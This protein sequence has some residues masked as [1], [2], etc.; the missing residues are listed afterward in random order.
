MFRCGFCGWA[1]PEG[2]KPHRII[3]ERR[4]KVYASGK[5][6]G[7]GWEIA[8]EVFACQKCGEKAQNA[9]DK[10]A[11]LDQKDAKINEAFSTA[12]TDMGGSS[13]YE[14][15]GTIHFGGTGLGSVS[16]RGD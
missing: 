14:R 12:V 15:G 3:T 10:V 4:D 5:T 8:K 7:H 16:R 11:R 9:L 2:V 1:V 13:S 6:L